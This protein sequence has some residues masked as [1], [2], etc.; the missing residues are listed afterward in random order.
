MR[1]GGAMH[2]WHASNFRCVFLIS[3][4]VKHE[5]T[6]KW[7]TNVIRFACL[8]LMQPVITLRPITCAACCL[9]RRRTEPLQVFLKRSCRLLAV[10]RGLPASHPPRHPSLAPATSRLLLRPQPRAARWVTMYG[11]NRCHTSLDIMKLAH[12]FTCFHALFCRNE[13]CLVIALQSAL[14]AATSDNQ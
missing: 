13:L 12:S 8:R 14:V 6:M 9:C 2:A 7:H 4:R 3:R 1:R 11:C 5:L 10:A